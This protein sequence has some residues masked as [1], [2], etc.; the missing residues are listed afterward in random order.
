[1]SRENKNLEWDSQIWLI[2][3]Q[4]DSG[5]PFYRLFTSWKA[6]LYSYCREPKVRHPSWYHDFRVWAIKPTESNGTV[7]EITGNLIYAAQRYPPYES[8]IVDFEEPCAIP[9]F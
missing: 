4:P 6:L 7:R 2:R 9:I 8:D 3:Y 1:M 5:E